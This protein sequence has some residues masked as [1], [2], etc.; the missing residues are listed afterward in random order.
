MMWLPEYGVGMFAMA[1]VTYA[2]P[3]RAMNEAF[4]ALRKTGGLKPRVLPPS[5]VL[6]STRDLIF[7]LWKEWNSSAAGKMAAGN[8][9]LG[10]PETG[11]RSEIERLKAKV[12]ICR[13]A[14]AV[15]PENW[16]RG[17]FRLNCERGTVRV[18][19]TLAPTQPPTVRYLRL[20]EDRPPSLDICRP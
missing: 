13:D 2:G 19:F 17:T 9:F 16:L 18:T 5:L 3:A 8:L 7:G 1:N 15:E 6:T 4:D 20:E 10:T 12:G 11:R 14:Q